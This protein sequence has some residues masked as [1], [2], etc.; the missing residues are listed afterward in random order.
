MLFIGKYNLGSIDEA[1]S[2]RE[3]ATKFILHPDWKTNEIKYDADIAIIII[4][5]PVE[6]TTFI[7]P[8]CLWNQE[9]VELFYV[10]GKKGRIAG[11]N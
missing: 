11:K 2:I 8:A 7:R 4:E 9:A 3:K 6:F 1:G 5:K 10:V